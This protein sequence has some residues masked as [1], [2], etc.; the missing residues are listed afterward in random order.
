MRPGIPE[1]YG[2]LAHAWWLYL[3][4]GVLLLVALGLHLA[5]RRLR[6]GDIVAPARLPNLAQL[7]RAALERLEAAEQSYA[8]T[9][10][11][12]AA[13]LE[14]SALVREFVGVCSDSNLD[15]RG[16]DEAHR[17]ALDDPRFAGV[18]ALVDDCAALGFAPA[19]NGDV[20]NLV[21]R[22]REVLESWQ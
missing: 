19:A 4:V 10:D 11:A 13:A 6:R 17:L 3:L 5:A 18:A 8:S 16:S 20:H 14:I 21:A 12:R 15:F 2:P 1:P 9:G 22:A 7:R